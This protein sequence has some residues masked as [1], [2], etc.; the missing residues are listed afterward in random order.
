MLHCAFRYSSAVAAA[1][2]S[3]STTGNECN[4]VRQIR[5]TYVHMQEK[6][7]RRRIFFLSLL[8]PIWQQDTPTRQKEEGGG[9]GDD[10]HCNEIRNI[11]SERSNQ[12]R[13]RR[14]RERK[15]RKRRR[16]E[17]LMDQASFSRLTRRDIIASATDRM[18]SY[19]PPK[20]KS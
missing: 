6:A 18:L 12:G 17:G 8:H 7:R 11:L 15:R 4:I 13:R 3:L 1:R 16:I 19:L 9:Y 20:F 10:S 14:Q 2:Q 5:R